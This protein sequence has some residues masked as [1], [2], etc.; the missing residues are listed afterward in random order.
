VAAAYRRSAEE[1]DF[2]VREWE[3][4]LLTTD[5]AA[6]ETGYSPEHLRRLVREGKLPAERRDGGKTHIH[7][8]RRHLPR[9]SAKDNHCGGPK[10][11]DSTYDPEED[12]R[13][14][15]ERLGR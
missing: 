11:Q 13:D 14:I 1:L 15:A 12:A 10:S 7:V 6:G 2:L 5:E 9:K 3:D 4:E 8:R